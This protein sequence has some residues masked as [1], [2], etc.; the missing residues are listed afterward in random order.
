M[1]CVIILHMFSLDYSC[2]K[3][4]DRDTFAINEAQGEIDVDKWH[5]CYSCCSRARDLL[6]LALFM[7]G[8]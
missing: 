8:W 2:G 3:V 5:I 4:D 6:V 1:I 7:L